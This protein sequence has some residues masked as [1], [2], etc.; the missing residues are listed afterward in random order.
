ME[1]DDLVATWTYSESEND[2]LFFQARENHE[3]NPREER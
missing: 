3:G 2:K 1:N